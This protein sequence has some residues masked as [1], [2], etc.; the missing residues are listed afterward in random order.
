MMVPWLLSSKTL[1]STPPPLWPHGRF[2]HD[3]LDTYN[4]SNS[5]PF[6]KLPPDPSSFVGLA[7]TGGTLTK[8][9]RTLACPA[10]WLLGSTAGAE[11]SSYKKYHNHA[12]GCHH[13][14]LASNPHLALNSK[15][16]CPLIFARLP[17][18]CVSVQHK[19]ERLAPVTEK[20]LDPW[21]TT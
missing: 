14:L 6:S 16:I 17:L 7:D 11:W 1:L 20:S 12:N 9:S 2:W 21:F 18:P 15:T 5:S 8:E 3:P 19:I 13:I 4:L 10:A